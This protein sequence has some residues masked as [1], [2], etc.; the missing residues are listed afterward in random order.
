[1][2]GLDLRGWDALNYLS[3]RCLLPTCPNVINS[4]SLRDY[5]LI[6]LSMR[7]NIIHYRAFL[8]QL[9]TGDIL[10][11]D[12]NGEGLGIGGGGGPL[13]LKA[14]SG[15]VRDEMGVLGAVRARPCV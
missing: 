6:P 12:L 10:D 4:A 5:A 11:I 7:S 8:W 1:M 3:L 15:R 13:L 14:Q 2:E 9:Y